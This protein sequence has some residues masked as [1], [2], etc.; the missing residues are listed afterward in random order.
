[1]SERQ[2]KV[3][4]YFIYSSH[5]QRVSNGTGGTVRGSIG[6]Q[7]HPGSGGVWPGTVQEEGEAESPTE[8]SAWPLTA[9]SASRGF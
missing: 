2:G 4:T 3:Q 8:C 1:M 9:D 5:T 7:E 6:G